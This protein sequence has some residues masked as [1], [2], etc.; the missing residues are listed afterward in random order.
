METWEEKLARLSKL[1]G[2]SALARRES[3]ALSSA[4][5]DG[6]ATAHRTSNYRTVL[7]AVQL[8]A[9]STDPVFKDEPLSHNVHL[10]LYLYLQLYLGDH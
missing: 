9:P 3:W 5:R 7:R 8:P 6:G 4:D 2:V 10:H 1:K